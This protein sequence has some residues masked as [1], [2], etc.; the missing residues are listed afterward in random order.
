MTSAR[1]HEKDLSLKFDGLYIRSFTVWL[2]HVLGTL[3]T[4]NEYVR[5]QRNEYQCGVF[6]ARDC[7]THTQTPKT[8][9][10]KIEVTQH[11]CSSMGIS[12]GKY[13]GITHMK[14]YNLH[15]DTI[16]NTQYNT[17]RYYI[18]RQIYEFPDRKFKTT[19]AKIIIWRVCVMPLTRAISP[20]WSMSGMTK[21][22]LS[23]TFETN[24]VRLL[25]W[26]VFSIKTMWLCMQSG[27]QH[28]TKSRQSIRK[29]PVWKNER[30][31]RSLVSPCHNDFVISSWRKSISPRR[32]FYLVRVRI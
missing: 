29:V 25:D 18:D 17:F 9:N 14:D 3:E 15:R 4:P 22:R 11:I 12:S 21:A 8:N 30:S 26:K 16:Q 2:L 5:R 28:Q 27:T 6:P 32:R 13:P 24:H 31:Y 23:Q 20:N 7:I 10:K 1:R 19:F